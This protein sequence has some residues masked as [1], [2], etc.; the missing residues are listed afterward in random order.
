M[1]R[2][3]FE[4]KKKKINSKQG[5]YIKVT[6]GAIKLRRYQRVIG[7]EQGLEKIFVLPVKIPPYEKLMGAESWGIWKI[8]GECLLEVTGSFWYT[9]TDTKQ[10]LFCLISL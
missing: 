10:V 2:L 1:K 8:Q 6:I 3:L 5:T 9:A 4:N 7:K